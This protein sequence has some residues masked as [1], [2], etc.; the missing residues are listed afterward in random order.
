METE[1]KKKKIIAK[2]ERPSIEIFVAL[3][4]ET[5]DLYR[6][7]NEITSNREYMSYV[8]RRFRYVADKDDCEIKIQDIRRHFDENQELWESE[9]EIYYMKILR[10]SEARL[11]RLMENPVLE[12]ST[13]EE[14]T[15]QKNQYIEEIHKRTER[16]KETWGLDIPIYLLQKDNPD[17]VLSEL[18]ERGIIS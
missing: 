1:Q 12:N 7:L 14:W 5:K 18:K 15:F 6:R 9:R 4:Y 17:E 11:H 16:M 13:F 3:F 10:M 8:S 2:K